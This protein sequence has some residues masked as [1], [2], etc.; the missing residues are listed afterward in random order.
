MKLDEKYQSVH[1]VPRL[2]LR[3]K[4]EQGLVPPETQL[5]PIDYSRIADIVRQVLLEFRKPEP[6]KPTLSRKEASEYIGVSVWTLD[7]LRMRGL[8][9]ACG[10]T[11]LPRYA[12]V[13][14]DRYIKDNSF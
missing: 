7:R 14:L 12:R 3:E 10:G 2:T 5:G 4:R 11:R 13:E 6:S 9:K 8:L 1:P